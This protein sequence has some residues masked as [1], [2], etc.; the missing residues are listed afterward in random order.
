[1]LGVYAT[2]GFSQFCIFYKSKNADKSTVG[3][4]ICNSWDGN[5]NDDDQKQIELLSNVTS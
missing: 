1:M 5:S 3:D 4:A 2:I